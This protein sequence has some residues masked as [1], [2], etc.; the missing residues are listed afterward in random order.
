LLVLFIV[1]VCSCEK[2]VE[3]PQPDFSANQ[4][5]S[6]SLEINF[7]DL[8][9]NNPT[10][11]EWHFEGGK[12]ETSTD[13][14]P[15]ITYVEPG[16]YNVTLIAKNEG[17]KEEIIKYAYVNII[18]FVNPLFTD[19]TLTFANR[20]IIIPAKASAKFAVIENYLLDCHIETQGKT[21]SGSDAGLLIFWDWSIDLSEYWYYLPGLSTEYIYFYITNNSQY[22]L[23]AFYVNCGNPYCESF[24]EFT[25][26]ND[27]IRHGIGYYDAF[28]GMEVRSYFASGYIYGIEPTSLYIPWEF[29]QYT[30][31]IIGTI[32][33]SSDNISTLNLFEKNGGYSESNSD[34]EAMIQKIKNNPKTKIL[35]QTSIK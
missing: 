2:D 32:T 13:Q 27:G 30:D 7:T 35:T 15:T 10:N 21:P 33:K 16:C 28:K 29:D 14:N 8:S 17:G 5:S 23:S 1:S 9:T 11:W 6:N 25:I 20:S 31:L 3:K 19:M 24:E 34:I 26:P 4:S 12:P 18:Q 22:N